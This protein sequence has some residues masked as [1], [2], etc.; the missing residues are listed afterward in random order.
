MPWNGNIHTARE[1]RND[2]AEECPDGNYEYRNSGTYGQS[3]Y[4]V[5]ERKDGNF[6]VY[7]QSD[8]KKEHSH[9]VVDKDGNLIAHYHDTLISLLSTLTYEDLET[10]SY[11]SNEDCIKAIQKVL[12]K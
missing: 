5:R 10:I 2:S 11:T 9:D 7:I 3:D 6:D 12:K 1:S 8:S 4:T